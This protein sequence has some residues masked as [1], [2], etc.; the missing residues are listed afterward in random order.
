MSDRAFAAAAL[1]CEA[2]CAVPAWSLPSPPATPSQSVLL[3]T[4]GVAAALQSSCS[5]SLQ[6]LGGSHMLLAAR[7]ALPMGPASA[8]FTS[9]TAQA[10][11]APARNTLGPGRHTI[12]GLGPG[13]L[14]PVT[15]GCVGPKTPSSR[16][17]TLSAGQARVQQRRQ[18]RRKFEAMASFLAG[19]GDA[20][21]PPPDF[22]LTQPPPPAQ[23]ALDRAA[24]VGLGSASGGSSMTA[25]RPRTVGFAVAAF[26]SAVAGCSTSGGAGGKGRPKLSVSVDAA[27]G[28]GL[29]E[30]PGSASSAGGSKGRTPSPLTTPADH[31]STGRGAGGLAC[32]SSNSGGGQAAASGSSHQ[33]AASHASRS[34]VRSNQ[35]AGPRHGSMAGGVAARA[36]AAGAA[37]HGMIPGHPP[38]G[39]LSSCGGDAVPC[40]SS[41]SSPVK[42]RQQVWQEVQVMRAAGLAAGSLSGSVTAALAAA[43]QS[44]AGLGSSGGWGS[45]RHASVSSWDPGTTPPRPASPQVLNLCTS[46]PNTSRPTSPLM[47]PPACQ[48]STKAAATAAPQAA[49]SV[50]HADSFSDGSGA[51]RAFRRDWEPAVSLLSLSGGIAAAPV[52]IGAQ[53]GAAAASHAASVIPRAAV[54]AADK[55]VCF[56]TPR[57][58]EADAAGVARVSQ[59]HAAL[60]AAAAHSMGLQQLHEGAAQ[61]IVHLPAVPSV[62]HSRSAHRQLAADA[63]GSKQ[64]QQQKQELTEEQQVR[65]V[66]ATCKALGSAAAAE[67]FVA[68]LPDDTEVVDLSTSGVQACWCCWVQHVSLVRAALACS[69]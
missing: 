38:A 44:A 63:A 42:L 26:A 53:L 41:G 17:R 13:G 35:H 64:Q 10:Q 32:G 62:Q 19:S 14:Q 55:A 67:A 25:G 21:P 65:L 28:T 36:S 43:R 7:A 15:P 51:A 40:S 60:E 27:A 23:T 34:G 54:A 31:N 1:L 57:T 45:H 58:Q 46:S 52:Q 37:A 69:S 4:D 22:M 66:Q 68:S 47:Q 12:L 20:L 59:A 11:Q 2:A 24:G 33:A 9:S 48:P 6:A 16:R 3:V 8:S 39:M 50:L 29:E 49:A 61:H 56:L 18:I 5:Y 30:G